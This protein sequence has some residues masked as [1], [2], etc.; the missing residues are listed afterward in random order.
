M[1]TSVV[2]IAGAMFASTMLFGV[3]RSECA[4]HACCR[5]AT[6]K[7]AATADPAAAERLKMKFGR[8]IAPAAPVVTAMKQ[9][10]GKSKGAATEA[11]AKG[12]PSAA[13]R[14]RMK[15]GRAT[16]EAQP[17]VLASAS[18]DMCAGGCCT[19]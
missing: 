4:N 19:R 10:D 13:E 9:C 15:F 8:A 18:N 5:T 7:A 3:T 1:K 2:I 12:D 16:T 6:T 14:F 11:I 17:I